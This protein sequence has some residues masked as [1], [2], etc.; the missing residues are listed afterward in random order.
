MKV[1]WDDEIPN[2]W[3][4]KTSSS[5]HQSV[6][7][8]SHLTTIFLWFSDGFPMVF[9]WFSMMYSSPPEHPSPGAAGAYPVAVSP[10]G[11]RSSQALRSCPQK[12]F[13]D[14]RSDE[15][16]NLG[17]RDELGQEFMESAGINVWIDLNYIIQYYIY[18]HNTKLDVIVYIY[19]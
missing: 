4:N 11:S 15:A 3:E 10:S 9:P 1:N 17:E 5:H 16:P 6:M 18:I 8:T 14:S 7:F 12:S 2:L 13:K 19:I